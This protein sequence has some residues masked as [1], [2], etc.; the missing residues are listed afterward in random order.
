MNPFLEMLRKTQASPQYD[1]MLRFAAPLYDHFGINHFWYYQITFS[2]AY[3]Y[4]GTHAAWSEYCFSR[5]LINHFPCLRHP[6]ALQSGVS[7]MKAGP[8]EVQYKEVL[9][10]AWNRFHINFNINL[11]ENSPEGIEAFGFATR[12]DDHKADERLLNELPLLRYFTQVFRKKH[13]K[14]FQILQDNRVDLSSHMGA[15]FY[16]RP[17][18]IA[19]PFQRARFLCQLGCES[20][21]SLTPREKEILKLLASGFPASYI[22]KEIHLGIRTVENYIAALKDKLSSSSKVELIKKAQEIASTGLLD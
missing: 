9:E 21:L 12:F 10:I 3:A 8:H 1:Q 17:K 7:L 6:Q 16:E 2:G 22:Q 11:F 19:L 4:M 20:F 18:E 14:L 15:I 13:A 5:S